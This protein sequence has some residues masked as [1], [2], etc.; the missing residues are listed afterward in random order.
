MGPGVSSEREIL[1][2][3]VRRAADSR[4]PGLPALILRF[5][6][7]DDPNSGEP[8]V[9]EDP[10]RY[11]ESPPGAV[12]MSEIAAATTVS[13]LRGKTATERKTA[14]KEI[15]E[16]A[17]SGAHPPPRLKLAALL[18]EMYRA[19]DAPGHALLLEIMGSVPLIYGP[20]QAV[21]TIYKL[22]EERHDALMFAVLATRFDPRPT[23]PRNEVSAGTLVYLARRAWRFMRLLGRTLPGVY[24]RFAVE[25]LRRYPARADLSRAWIANQIWGHRALIGT[26]RVR[27]VDWRRKPTDRYLD[28]AWKTSADPLLSLLE[29]CAHDEVAALALGWLAKDFPD[30]L[31]APSVPWLVRLSA[32][33][34]PSIESFVVKV[35][36]E[37]PELHTSRFRELGLRSVVLDMVASKSAEAR[38]F[39]LE[40]ARRHAAE[41]S[42]E[43]VLA[44][45]KPPPDSETAGVFEWS[46]HVDREVIAFVLAQLGPVDAK[47]IGLRALAP[48]LPRRE[49]REFAHKKAVEGFS[50][51]DIDQ[52]T[53][54]DVAVMHEPA[55]QLLTALYGHHK[56]KI[57]AAYLLALLEDTRCDHRARSFALQGLSQQSG[58]AI[59]FDWVKR[60][61]L[62]DRLFPTVA[63]WLREGRFKHPVLDVEWMKGLVFRPKLRAL[64]IEVFAHADWVPPAALGAGWLIAQLD[65]ADPALS[66]FAEE[67]L[68][69]SFAP[70]ALGGI[71]KVL[72]LVAK[73]SEGARRFAVRYLAAHHPDLAG[74][75]ARGIAPQLAHADFTLARVRPLLLHA[76]EEV[77]ALG[78]RIGSREVLAWNDPTLPYVLAESP[79]REARG[80]AREVLS[81][82]GEEGGAPVA[83]LDRE[84]VF[85]LAESRHKATRELGVALIRQHY[86]R[87][88][89]RDR[90]AW[91]MESP[92]REV[93]L[94]AVRILW[95]KHR[96]GAPASGFRPKVAPG[97]AAP[98]PHAGVLSG[99]D[100]ELATFLRTSLFGLPPGRMERRDAKAP[101]PIPAS[102]AK[103]RLIE[104]VRDMAIEDHDFGAA[105]A[106]ILRDF[107]GSA[108]KGEWQAC[109]AALARIAQVHPDLVL[110]GG[111][112][113]APA[114][115]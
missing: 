98:D 113:A 36:R 90:L 15:W 81:A 1:F 41:L 101:R 74:E 84:A 11:F 49:M 96:P 53:F 8:E 14:R 48:L 50:P 112:S 67:H 92:D 73:P 70:A 88:D 76:D 79:F 52:V 26:G 46:F 62:D 93:R 45:L 60:A 110:T 95:E 38:A 55:R 47:K 80:L 7:Q 13:A 25:V 33:R 42:V 35:L 68:L 28:E 69:A 105:A 56:A 114:R 3:D 77:R 109:V 66:K 63:E 78:A 99:R 21:K 27:R 64:A 54:V 5:L 83:W 87:L 30:A 24:T 82:A 16:A 100:R 20:W 61:L 58:E 97:V 17:L 115:S 106:P 18:I 23:L 43:E 65:H 31:R 51:A 9:P 107:A 104:V 71:E 86:T 12:G 59:G 72:E 22:S 10:E 57:P 94:F 40:Y 32:R 19:G 111:A 4:S 34:L 103:Q 2:D 102:V 75:S 108:A 85:A 37:T 29:S 91:L 6:E 44:W 39:G 89:A